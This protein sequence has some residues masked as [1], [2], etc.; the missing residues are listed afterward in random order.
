MEEHRGAL[1]KMAADCM[2]RMRRRR[3]RKRSGISGSAA[4]L[5]AAAQREVDLML[6]L[7]LSLPV[8]Q[9]TVEVYQQWCSTVVY[10][11]LHWVYKSILGIP[12]YT[13]LFTGHTRVYPVYPLTLG[14]G[15][16]YVSSHWLILFAS[17]LD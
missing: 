9:H 16:T 15:S 13:Q 3:R 10:S 17:W 1:M 8:E 14:Y 5:K 12:G 4:V 11:A 7:P 6:L 2:G